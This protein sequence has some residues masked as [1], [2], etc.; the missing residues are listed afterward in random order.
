LQ[1]KLGK[2]DIKFSDH[3]NDISVK[4]TNNRVFLDDAA[5]TKHF[6]DY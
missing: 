1:E 4:E 3:T 5:E 6:S 2:G